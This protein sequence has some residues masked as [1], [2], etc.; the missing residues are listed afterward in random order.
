MPQLYSQSMDG[1]TRVHL[2]KL[3]QYTGC[4]QYQLS[5]TASVPEFLY[6]GLNY[7]VGSSCSSGKASV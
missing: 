6:F 5:Y 7:T 4:A 2:L 1:V 3:K